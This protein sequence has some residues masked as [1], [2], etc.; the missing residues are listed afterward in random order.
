LKRLGGS[1]TP[2]RLDRWLSGTQK[3]APGSKMYL[4]IDDPA[5][6]RAIISYLGAV[7]KASPR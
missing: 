5:Q 6:R 2:A 3:M 7:S 1:W 4:E